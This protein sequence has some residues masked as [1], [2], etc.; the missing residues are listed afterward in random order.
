MNVTRKID[1]DA[2][3]LFFFVYLRARFKKKFTTYRYANVLLICFTSSREIDVSF[4]T[5]FFFLIRFSVFR[6]FGKTGLNFH[7]PKLSTFRSRRQAFRH[8]TL[9]TDPQTD[10]L[11]ERSSPERNVR[12]KYRCSCVLQF[13]CRRG[14]CSVLHRFTSQVIHRSGFCILYHSLRFYA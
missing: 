14:V 5:V 9:S 10:V 3:D 6:A 13:T 1:D 4:S 2:C 7:D 12:S 11:R 8:L